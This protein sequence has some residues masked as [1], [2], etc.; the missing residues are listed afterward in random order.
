M[1]AL[2]MAKR[3]AMLKALKEHHES[4]IS[5]LNEEMNKLGGDLFK[6]FADGA[7]AL[8]I[9]GERL[10]PDKQDRIIT[11][12]LKYRPT[13]VD[14]TTF[15]MWLRKGGEGALIKETI[16]PKTLESWVGKR[17]KAN[18]ALPDET[19]LKVW[20]Q[21]TAQV[22]R[23]PKGAPVAPVGAEGEGSNE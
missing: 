17:K 3:F 10:F 12:L 13:I 23:A 22:R 19:M 20:T 9:D 11:P 21:E 2:E 18:V 6:A 8:R 15:F 7:K 16:H 14:E 5:T 4:V 1:D